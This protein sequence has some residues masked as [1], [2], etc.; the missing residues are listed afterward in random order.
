MWW[1]TSGVLTSTLYMYKA[2][3]SFSSLHALFIIPY[4]SI[5]STLSPLLPTLYLAKSSD[6]FPL[7]LLPLVIFVPSVLLV[8]L[9]PFDL[10]YIPLKCP[11]SLQ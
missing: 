11:G 8:Y 3:S 4:A 7:Q 5:M 1:Q 10:L 2:L 9:D 6:N